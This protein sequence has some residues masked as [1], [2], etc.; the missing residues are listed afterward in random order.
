M[1]TAFR[2]SLRLALVVTLLVA[3]FVGH[4][5]WFKP[6]SINIFFERVFAEYLFKNPEMMSGMRILPAWMNWYNDDLA[7]ASLAFE[8]QMREK[9][10]NDYATLRSYDRSA[11]DSETQVSYDLSLIHI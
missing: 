10:K 4:S 1:R 6:L 2:W 11:L 5:I 8:D 3:L 9:L 7:D